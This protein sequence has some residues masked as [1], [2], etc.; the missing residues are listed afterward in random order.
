MAAVDIDEVE[1]SLVGDKPGQCLGRGTFDLLDPFAERGQVA[2]EA[3]LDMRKLVAPFVAQGVFGTAAECIDA[4]QPAFAEIVEKEDRR[5]ALPG[6][7][8]QNIE[9]LIAARL[10]QCGPEGKEARGPVGRK[11]LACKPGRIIRVHNSHSLRQRR[12]LRFPEC[13]SSSI[14]PA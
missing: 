2:V 10:E 8:L 4:C 5:P 6:A 14:G 11:A 3:L 13:C 1:T 12:H 7:D 9:G